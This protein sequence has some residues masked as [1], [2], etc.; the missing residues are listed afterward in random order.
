MLSVDN[1]QRS[2]YGNT[3]SFTRSLTTARFSNQ[4]AQNYPNP[5]NPQTTLAFSIKDVG[6]VSLVIYDVAGRR[7]RELVDEHRAPGIYKVVW[8]GRDSKG[9]L[10]A[11]G[12]YFYKL[13][14]GS[15]ADTK[16]MVLL[17]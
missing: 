6:K 11:S 13:V 2:I 12:V 17:K 5:F 1:S 4:L 7:V 9:G 15:F 8:D 10:V 16:K 3:Q 14:A